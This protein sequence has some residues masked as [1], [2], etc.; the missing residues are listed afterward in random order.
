MEEIIKET[1]VTKGVLVGNN[2]S[3]SKAT[4][5]QTA[6]YII[7]FLFGV[8]EA[9]LTFRILF[10]VAGA[11]LSSSFVRF[12]YGLSG[13]FIMPFEGIFRRGFSQG[14]ETTSILEP[15]ALVALLFY[16]LLSWGVV[17]LVRIM[18]GEV[19]VD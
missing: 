18:S 11:S 2:P 19:Q 9:F 13:V 8:L 1:V 7:Y 4:D 3:N 12:V 10:K 5:T 15:S 16:A 17:K 14:I 6:E